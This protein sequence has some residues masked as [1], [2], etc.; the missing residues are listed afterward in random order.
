MEIYL[1]RHTKPD[2]AKGICYGQTDLAL[3]ESFAEETDII[4]TKLKG[5][6][7]SLAIFSSPLRRCAALAKA[8]FPEVSITEDPRLMELDFG[9]WEMLAWEAIPKAEITPWMEDFVQVPCPS[10]ESYRQ[11]Y[12]RCVAFITDLQQQKTDKAIIITHGGPIRAI[13]AHFNDIAL[14][15]SF[16]LKVEYG[17]VLKLK[18]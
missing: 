9:S 18:G 13:H 6:A 15:D 5:Q 1:I 3:A 10:G 2:I 8:L 17:E 12:D 11:L 4:R 14:K 7:T 16:S